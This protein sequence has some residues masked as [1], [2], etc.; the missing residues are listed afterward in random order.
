MTQRNPMNERYSSDKPAG[1]T[2]KSAASAKPKSKAAATVHAPR[3]KTAKEKKAEQ[4]EREQKMQERRGATSSVHGVY[5]IPTDEYKRLK[6]VWWICLIV[7]IVLTI[8]AWFVLQIPEFSTFGY[9]MLFAGYAAIIYG[10]YVDLWKIRKIR[11][12]YN[13][14]V[15][16]GKSKEARAGQK[17]LAA[18]QR[19]ARKEAE[20]LE[21]LKKEQGVAEEPEK[22]GFF[23]KMFGGKKQASEVVETNTD[24]ADSKE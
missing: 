4:K 17:K 7:A 11:R 13:E 18:E 16:Y 8:A 9:I 14:N 1:Q 20:E 19:A 5:D 2:R 23:S 22:K 10:L 12:E 6:R 3:E 15:T 21:R 24:S